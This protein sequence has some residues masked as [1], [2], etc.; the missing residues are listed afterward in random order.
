MP[1]L[2]TWVPSAR[3][4]DFSIYNLPFGIFSTPDRSPRAGI[5]IGNKIIDLYSLADMGLLKDLLLETSVFDQDNLNKFIGLGKKTTVALREQIQAWL[6]QEKS[7]LKNHSKVWVE[8]SGAHMH[9]PVHI[10]DYTDFYS[11]MEHAI[12]VGKMFR[13][14]ENALLPNWKHLPVAYHGRAS[15]I[16][17]SGTPIRRP[18]GQVLPK[19]AKNPVFQATDQL[20]FE[21]EMGFIIGKNSKLGQ[22]VSAEIASDYIFGLVLFND[23]SARDIQK[24]E[25]VPLGPFLGKNFASSMSPWIVTLEALDHFKTYGPEQEPMVLPYLKT[26]GRKNY[27]IELSVSIQPEKGQEQVVCR[28]NTRYLYWNIAQQLAHHT[29][30]GC[31]VR[32]GDLMA[33]GT[34]SGPGE[35]AYGSLLE[36]SRGGRTKLTLKNN[37][38]RTFLEDHDTVIL[39]GRAEKSGIQVGFGEVRTEI[40]PT[41][42]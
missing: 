13:D 12:N 42:S 27:D 16:V 40:L 25:Y 10:G 14:P 39:R 33:S 19:G 21:L 41:Y 20:D 31:N 36:L 4:S 38:N 26:S 5:A 34:I 9:L 37:T 30:N 6:C 1:L 24:W 29:V 2:N 15:S 23:W 7:P 18:Q 22:A 28:S 8:Q 32:V 17:A 3:N 11:S 35:G